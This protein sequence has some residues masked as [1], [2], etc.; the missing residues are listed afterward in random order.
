MVTWNE[1]LAATLI[2]SNGE[3]IVPTLTSFFKWGQEN[4]ANAGLLNGLFASVSLQEKMRRSLAESGIKIIYAV[5]G[6]N[7]AVLKRAAYQWTFVFCGTIFSQSWV[8]SLGSI[9]V[10]ELVQKPILF[11]GLS[12]IAP[13]RNSEQV[14]RLSDQWNSPKKFV[15]TVLSRGRAI[16]LT[17]AKELFRNEFDVLQGIREPKVG[18]NP[19]PKKQPKIVS[20]SGDGA[21]GKNKPKDDKAAKNPRFVKHIKTADSQPSGKAAFTAKVETKEET[22]TIF[23]TL[24]QGELSYFV[25][26]PSLDCFREFVDVVSSI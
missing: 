8:S 20:K 23:T 21:M 22:K 24:N 18:T 3:I 7:G 19:R 2:S 12:K 15:K 6:V 10:D 13:V 16:E 4:S 25:S 1:F 17:S 14:P 5:G 9:A 26:G 11:P